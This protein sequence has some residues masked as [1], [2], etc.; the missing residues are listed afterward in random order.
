M[1]PNPANPRATAHDLLQFHD[2]HLPQIRVGTYN[3]QATHALAP[4]AGSTPATDS[5]TLTFRIAG[6]QLSLPAGLV[7]ATYPAPTASGAFDGVLPHVTLSRATLPWERSADGM[8][9]PVPPW[10]LLLVLDG[11]DLA[12]C[13]RASHSAATLPPEIDTQ[14]TDPDAPVPVIT[15]PQA[16]AARLLPPA[17]DLPWLAHVRSIQPANAPLEAE[18]ATVVA[19]SLPTP[20]QENTV[21]L[22]SVEGRYANAALPQASGDVT[23][24]VLHE[25]SFH[26]DPTQ[27]HS[28]VDLLQ[29]AAPDAGHPPP[30]LA[31]PDTPAPEAA[32][33]IAAG[34]VPVKHYMRRG[35][36]SVAWFHGPLCPVA[37]QPPA[38]ALPARHCDALLLM[39]QD[40]AML[41]IS[42]AAA[43]ELGRLLMLQS[44]AIA[45]DLYH[46]KRAHA[47]A[48]HHQQKPTGPKAVP[49]LPPMPDSVTDWLDDAL[50]HLR[51]MP[52]SYLVPDATMLAPDSLRFFDVDMAWIAALQDGALAVGRTDSG[53]AARDADI[54][55]HLPMQ[56]SGLLLRSAAVVDFPHLEVDGY[57]SAPATAP[58]F[59]ATP[60]PKPRM[61]RLSRDVLLVLFQGR[62]TAADIHLHPQAVHFGF[63]ACGG[64]TFDK[65]PQYTKGQTPGSFTRAPAHPAPK[66]LTIAP[67]N[68]IVAKHRIDM[69]ALAH[70]MDPNIQISEFALQM[71]EGVPLVR[72][73]RQ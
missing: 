35:D 69:Q 25:W 9:D 49:K 30:P 1:P 8:A 31:L 39:D 3:V 67:G 66:P 17:Q 15:L 14:D 65:T 34:Y 50:L 61:E 46:W 32:S 38:L 71:L 55:P 63:A 18:T 23:L 28:F 24:P 72:F 33:R 5:T 37:P 11:D 29:R 57:A 60:L 56:M 62:V 4:L 12:L 27:A 22:V 68:G 53:Q 54:A 19:S 41:D 13:T 2:A 64:G 43:W 21:L 58:D 42:Y 59:S 7:T 73:T 16:L 51:A 47:Q 70:R 20:G 26:C 10:L 36:Q 44:D 40:F 6:P 48:L 52:F 45:R